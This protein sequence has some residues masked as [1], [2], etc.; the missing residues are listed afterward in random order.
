MPE[1]DDGWGERAFLVA[2]PRTVT[3]D[4]YNGHGR[5]NPIART[6][7]PDPMPHL[8]RVIA[9]DWSGRKDRP[10][11]AIWLA[12]IRGDEVIRLENGRDRSQMTRHLVDELR[13][14]ENLIVGLDFAFSFP[15]W[16][17]RELGA[18]SGPGVWQAVQERGEDWLSDCP[19]PFWGR[20]GKKKPDLQE[21][22]RVTE[23]RAGER[24]GSQPKSVFQV[25]GAGAVG[26]G[27]VRGMPHLLRLMEM[28][29][30]IFPFQPPRLPMVLEIYPR[31]LTGPVVKSSAEDRR[32][33]VDSRLR[34]LSGDIRDAA[35]GSEDAF[36]ALVSAVVMAER[37]MEILALR[38]PDDPILALEG[39]IWSPDSGGLS[40]QTGLALGGGSPGEA[41]KHRVEGCP[42]CEPGPD[43]AV[44]AS[45]ARGLAIRDRFPVSKGHTLVIPRNHVARMSDLDAAA[46]ADLWRLV[47]EVQADLQAQLD[48]DGFNIGVNE[49]SAAGQTI[50]HS[51]IH[52]IP[53][54]EGDVEDPR[55]GV[56]WV[57]P[58]KARY[59]EEAE[60]E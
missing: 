20:P 47:G 13:R 30:N 35:I 41:G 26:T 6:P 58:E 10:D 17:C 15:A 42:F 31:T 29:Y 43:A 12:E 60:G 14:D 9:V 25:G 57:I 48:P 45:S 11:R 21:H 27:S 28:G 53:R 54:F 19:H 38:A 44:V 46:R 39:I 50:P 24:V 55:G 18:R 3:A 5:S 37:R 59:W 7:L 56:R 49:G 16:F 32:D 2:D 1:T 4:S 51:H 8:S 34:G 52:V 33:Y 36:D 23:Q 40:A 22:F